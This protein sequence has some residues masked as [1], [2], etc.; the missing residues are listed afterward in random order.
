MVFRG[1]PTAICLCVAHSV[2]QKLLVLASLLQ[3]V[4]ST[5]V[6]VGALAAQVACDSKPMHMS[7]GLEVATVD[8]G[9]GLR[10]SAC[11]PYV[12]IVMPIR[13]R[14]NEPQATLPN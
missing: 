10:L 14:S 2:L 12:L 3:Y 5:L 1:S 6:P 13:N 9:C 7:Y 11:Q 4:T 8:C